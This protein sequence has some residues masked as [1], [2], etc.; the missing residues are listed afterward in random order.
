MP[1]ITNTIPNLRDLGG[2]PTG[3]GHRTKRGVFYRSA[4]LGE[5][6][7]EA[8]DRLGVRT[9]IDLRSGP[10]RLRQPT[11]LP[12][13]VKTV[14][15][16]VLAARPD[17]VAAQ[18]AR[19]LAD[20]ERATRLLADGSAE[21]EITKIYRFFVLDGAAQHAYRTF[22]E[23]VAD[24]A[25]HPLLFHCTAGKDRTGWAATMLLWLAGAG[26]ADLEAEYLAVNPAVE[27]LFAPIYTVAAEHGLTRE[28][29]QP[30]LQ[31]RPA[32]LAEARRSVTEHFGTIEDYVTRG[33]RVDSDALDAVRHALLGR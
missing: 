33:L 18:F 19:A 8:L 16:D 28:L 10:E 21:R 1:S 30:V 11:E 14:I 12:P 13:G 23:V 27:E 29:L 3:S 7:A 4:H 31:V 17:G 32:Y 9:V 15:A 5:S 25:N 2:I 26:D 20:P 24:P 22:F 6:N